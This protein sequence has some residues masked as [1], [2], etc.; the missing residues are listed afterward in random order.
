MREAVG[1]ERMVGLLAMLADELTQ[2]F[3]PTS[4]MQGRE[5]IAG[6]AHAMV[7]ATS[8]VGFCSLSDLCRKVEAACRAGEAYEPLLTELRTRSAET[9]EEIAIFRAA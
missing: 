2:R 6:D 1:H 3:G 9:I 8:M 4:S 7:S 5:Q